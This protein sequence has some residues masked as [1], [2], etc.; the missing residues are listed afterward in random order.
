VRRQHFN[1]VHQ[2]RTDAKCWLPAALHV[3][4]SMLADARQVMAVAVYMYVRG[5]IVGHMVSDGSTLVLTAEVS[6]R[7]HH[8]TTGTIQCH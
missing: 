3:V 5:T 6:S 7:R 4:A 1:I 2:L 8:C